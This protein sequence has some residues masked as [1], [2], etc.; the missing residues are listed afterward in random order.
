M[1]E[2]F[3][4]VS[5]LLLA[6]PTSIAA[7]ARCCVRALLIGVPYALLW[8]ALAGVLR[9]VP[10]LGPLIATLLPTLLAFVTFPGWQ[11][12]LLTVGLS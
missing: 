7:L 10:L 5:H 1:T 12:A 4:R 8:G 2:A 9:F 3:L 11:H 6:Q